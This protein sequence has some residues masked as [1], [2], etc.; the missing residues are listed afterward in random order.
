MG[1]R[2]GKLEQ[3]DVCGWATLFYASFRVIF[4]LAIQVAGFDCQVVGILGINRGSIF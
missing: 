1:P 4:R 3:D 2:P